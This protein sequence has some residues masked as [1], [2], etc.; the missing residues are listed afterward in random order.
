LNILEH[1]LP[2]PAALP[3][4][5][6]DVLLRLRRVQGFCLLLALSLS[7]CL[8]LC[9]ALPLL[10]QLADECRGLTQH[11]ITL[12]MAGI[13]LGALSPAMGGLIGARWQR[14]VARAAGFGLLL[15]ALPAIG[16]EAFN[17]ELE[18]TA[19]GVAGSATLLAT[20][21]PLPSLQPLFAAFLLPQALLLVDFSRREAGSGRRTCVLV[22]LL[23]GSCLLALLGW[24]MGAEELG[25]AVWPANAL[26]LSLLGMTLLCIA[27]MAEAATRP[28]MLSVVSS[29][30]IGGRRVRRLMLP[31]VLLP[32]AAVLVTLGGV[33]SGWLSASLAAA[34]Y[35]CAITLFGLFVI[36]HEGYKVNRLEAGLRVASLTDDLTHLYNRRAFMLLGEQA[37]RDA[38]RKGG[39]LSVLYFDLD[40]LKPINDAFGHQA[41]S[42]LLQE[43]AGL[44]RQV[45]R[46]SDVVARIGGDEF[47]VVTQA[48]GK[49]IQ[50]L[51]DRLALSVS[52]RNRHGNRPYLIRYSVG[53]A[54]CEAAQFTDFE[55]L[56]AQADARMYA[57]KHGKSG[58]PARLASDS[59]L[60][61]DQV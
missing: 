53:T 55:A 1:G 7:L 31:V 56:V 21:L 34:L 13:G 45:S 60:V 33:S 20:A 4:F 22:F 23:G 58:E 43:F 38:R 30:G 51:V 26:P 6:R 35:T 37:L 40:R 48:S 17:V 39:A 41:G 27:C 54:C 3:G 46:A 29:I 12:A 25:V 15:F 42:S 10:P 16:L 59:V 5:D 18:P 47:A 49:E 61:L 9:G 24:L 8:L 36:V 50:R 57:H 44:L 19:Q 32:V 11:G 2:V 28:G 14:R 52:E